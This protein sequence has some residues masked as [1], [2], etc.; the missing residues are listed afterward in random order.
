MLANQTR[1]F[2]HSSS[3]G[4]NYQMVFHEIDG[5][6]TWIEPMKN[7]TKGK[8][9]LAQRSAARMKL[10]GIVSKHQVV[11]NEISA[12]YKAEIWTTNMT[13]QRVPSDDHRRNIAGKAIQ[14]WRDHFVGVLGGTSRYFPLYMWCQAIPQM[15]WL[16]LLRQSNVNPKISANAH[17]YG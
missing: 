12:A 6:S 15:G 3:Q 13:L 10:Q 11:V 9:I 8:M 16:L 14:T 5:S 2:P 7:R 1:E 17:V 4:S